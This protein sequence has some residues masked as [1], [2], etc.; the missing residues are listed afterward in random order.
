MRTPRTALA[1]ALLLALPVVADGAPPGAPVNDDY[2]QS[3]QL[4]APSSKLERTNTLRD[5][6]DTTKASVQGDVFVPQQQPGGPTEATTCGSSGSYGKTVWYDFYPDVS[7]IARI[8]ANGYDT[9]IAVVPFNRRSAVPNFGRRR[10][11]NDSASTTEELLARVVKGRAYTIQIGGVGDVGGNLEFLF[12][13]LADTDGDGVLDDVDRCRR[14]RGPTSEAGCPERVRASVT[15]RARPL[16]DGIQLIGLGVKASRGARVLVRCRGCPSQVK[17][18]RGKRT[19]TL[20]FR[21]L[22]GRRLSAGSDLVIRVVRRNSIGA[23]FK[24]RITRGN[25][26]KVERC[27]NPG[28]RKPRRR[29]A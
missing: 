11:I 25:F 3:L 21:G 14:L 10:C 1:V 27:L 29:C 28:S 26:K 16:A 17:R 12:D 18:N 9:A 6:R 7:G 4:N 23:Y 22:N 24:Y 2:L 8:R 15:L 5:A 20:S 13:F 19:R